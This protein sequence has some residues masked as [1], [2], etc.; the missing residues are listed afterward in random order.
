MKVL[1]RYIV[2]GILLNSFTT[3]LIMVILLSFLTFIQ[4]LEQV[5]EGQYTTEDAF[6]FSLLSMFH[7][8]FEMFPVAALLGSLTALGSMSGH[9]ELTAIRAAGIS[10][11]RI[12]F[13]IFKAGVVMLTFIFVVGDLVAPIAE[14]KAMTLRAEKLKD[15]ITFQ[16]E[17]GF[18]ARDGQA[19]INIQT[20]LPGERLADIYIYEFDENQHLLSSTYAEQAIFNGKNWQ[21]QEIKKSVFHPQK[22]TI[23][24]AKI[25]HWDS[26]IEPSLM[27]YFTVKPTM[28]PIWNLYQ[29][30]NFLHKNNQKST[31]YEIAFWSK[32]L[33]PVATFFMMLLAL[34]FVLGNLRS[35]S[36]SQR[37]IVGMLA[38]TSFYLVN[39]LFAY[40]SVIYNIHPFLAACA[41]IILFVSGSLWLIHRQR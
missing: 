19:F 10:T 35:V 6:V 8:T 22:V 5:G 25:A 29:Y 24:T 38:G 28:L 1:D 20:I 15:Q 16:T 34:P 30:V 31:A 3:I 41:P 21:L 36:L 26:F 37:I 14:K 7:Y 12:L 40:L 18:W 13:S 33:T 39:R 9:S 11:Q 32:L 17:Y 4:E 2:K 23:E 27:G